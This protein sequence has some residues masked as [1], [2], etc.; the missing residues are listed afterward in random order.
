M[1]YIK[2]I[3]QKISRLKPIFS[4]NSKNG[5]LAISTSFFKSTKINSKACGLYK[6]DKD[7]RDWCLHFSDDEIL[8]INLDDY[9]AVICSKSLALELS[10][11]L[12]LTKGRFVISLDPITEEGLKLYPIITRNNLNQL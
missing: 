5:K 4:F 1:S 11:T 8:K 9:S 3:P 12:H 6:S 7:C 2:V 10:R